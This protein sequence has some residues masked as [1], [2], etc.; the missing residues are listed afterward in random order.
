M[1]N[2]NVARAFANDKTAKGENIF[3]E[4]NRKGELTIYSYGVHFEIAVKKEYG[5]LFNTKGYS[6]TTSR[7]K[8]MVKKY[9]RGIVIDMEDCNEQNAVNQLKTN[10]NNIERLRD[11][12]FRARNEKTKEIYQAQIDNL[13][14]Q[15]N[16]IK[17]KILPRIVMQEI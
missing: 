2:E 14:E 13:K 1:K 10:E 7:H 5:Y 3:S 6:S 17:E 9:L 16:I 8:T 11:N 4:L 12:K 15:N